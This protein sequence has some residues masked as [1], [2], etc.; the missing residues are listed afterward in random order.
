MVYIIIHP[1]STLHSLHDTWRT[2]N[3]FG[4][5][6]F[7]FQWVTSSRRLIKMISY[8]VILRSLEVLLQVTWNMILGNLGD[9]EFPEEW[10][11]PY[12]RFRDLTRAL[13]MTLV[14]WWLIQTIFFFL[15][16]FDW[17]R[18]ITYNKCALVD[19]RR[20]TCSD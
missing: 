13:I 1:K 15:K 10:K 18:S 20:K 8:K 3:W 7:F 17:E 14:S 12:Y 11:L 19:Y 4:S 5:I 2:V 6:S 16:I 9:S